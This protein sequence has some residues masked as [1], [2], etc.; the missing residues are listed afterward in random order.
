MKT[1]EQTP[2]TKEE[3]LKWDSVSTFLQYSSLAFLFVGVVILENM[4]KELAKVSVLYFAGFMFVYSTVSFIVTCISNKKTSIY[5]RSE[6]E[7]MNARH[8]KLIEA[9]KNGK[10]N[11]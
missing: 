3:Y 2:V 1:K 5:L 11:K 9:M 4:P 6:H 7:A 8:D 10:G